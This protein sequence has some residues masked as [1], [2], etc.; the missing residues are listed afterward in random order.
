[1]VAA[2]VEGRPTPFSSSALTS[3]ASEYAFGPFV[4]FSSEIHLTTSSSSPSASGGSA[5]TSSPSSSSSSAFFDFALSFI[6]LRKPSKSI[7]VAL[8][9]NS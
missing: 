8:A 9:V 5:A 7:S 4:C 1:M 3:D 6:T 2:Y